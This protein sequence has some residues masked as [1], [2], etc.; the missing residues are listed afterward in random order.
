MSGLLWFNNVAN[1]LL[2]IFS[3]VNSS[4]PVSQSALESFRTITTWSRRPQV[5]T[6]FSDGSA[7]ALLGVT[8]LALELLQT[9]PR[10]LTPQQ[11]QSF[12]VLGMLWK[13]SFT[14]PG[15]CL[16]DPWP[17]FNWQN[18]S[19]A[20][21][22]ASVQFCWCQPLA[23]KVLNVLL[24]FGLPSQS[25]QWHTR[26]KTKPSRPLTPVYFPC[27]FRKMITLPFYAKVSHQN[28]MFCYFSTRNP[29]SFP[30]IALKDSIP[31]CWWSTFLTS[32]QT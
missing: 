22:F 19:V 20:L 6:P 12:K 17:T 23:L 7:L 16:D 4:R 26:R 25:H 30:L 10:L 2:F 27:L 3:S 1:K 9:Y 28:L 14:F 15:L 24:P 5:I 11:L 13:N 31:F 29:W 32:A 21:V 8:Q 18:P